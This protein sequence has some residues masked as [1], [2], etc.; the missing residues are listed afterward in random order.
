MTDDQTNSQFI[1]RICKNSGKTFLFDTCASHSIVS[2]RDFEPA[3]YRTKEFHWLDPA[4]KIQSQ[5]AITLELDFGQKHSISWEFDVIDNIAHNLCGLD[6]MQ[7][8]NITLHPQ[9]KSISFNNDLILPPLPRRR[10][11][12]KKTTVTTTAKRKPAILFTNNTML[13]TD[14]TTDDEEDISHPSLQ[15]EDQDN[16]FA[17]FYN[18]I[19]HRESFPTLPELNSS[20]DSDSDTEP[21]AQ[22]R[23]TPTERIMDLPDTP[24]PIKQLLLKYIE[25]T[26][27]EIS[28]MKTVPNVRFEIELIE[29]K[30]IYS[31]PRPVPVQ[32][33]K[34]LR[35]LLRRYVKYKIISRASASKYLQPLHVIPKKNGKIRL[36][37]DLRKLNEI[38]VPFKHHIPKINDIILQIEQSQ[39]KIFTQIDMA[40]G[41]FNI[42]NTPKTAE[43]LTFSTEFGNFKLERMA[44]GQ[45][46]AGE[47]FEGEMKI[48][49]GDLDFVQSYLD[50]LMVI[51]KTLPEHY[52]HLD[53]VFGILQKNNFTLSIEKCSF[54]RS[55]ITF[56][57]YEIS[58]T[59]VKPLREKCIAI[60]NLTLPTTHTGL[61]Q[62][63]GI[64][65]WNR[66]FIRMAAEHLSTLYRL[67]D[68]KKKKQAL[69]WSNKDIRAFEATKEALNNCIQTTYFNPKYELSVYADSSSLALGGALI[70]APPE[71]HTAKREPEVLD[72]YSRPLN[73]KERLYS[74]FHKELFAIRDCLRHFHFIIFGRPLKIYSDNRAVVSVLTVSNNIELKPIVHR[75]FN[76]IIQYKPQVFHITSKENFLSDCFSRNCIFKDNP[77]PKL[78]PNKVIN[79]LELATKQAEG[80]QLQTS[81]NVIGFIRLAQMD[82]DFQM[83]AEQQRNDQEVQHNFQ[84]QHNPAIELISR[85]VENSDYSIIG[86]ISTGSFR[87]YITSDLRNRFF[88]KY[89]DQNHQ[90]IRRSTAQI[91]QVVYWPKMARDL[92]DL[93]LACQVCARNKVVKHEK[94]KLMQWVAPQGKFATVQCDYT[95]R[96]QECDGYNYILVIRDRAT[97]FT[98]CVPVKTQGKEE[99]IF[100]FMNRWVAYFGVCEQL[101]SDNYSTFLSA[102]F[103]DCL[104]F[105]GITYVPIETYTPRQNALCERQMRLLK[106]MLRTSENKFNWLRNIA[107][108]TL[109]M[110]NL[111]GDN[112]V[113]ANQSTFGIQLYIP[114]ALFNENVP[115][116]DTEQAAKMMEFARRCQ[117]TAFRRH[118]QTA[119]QDLQLQHSTHV[120]LRHGPKPRALEERYSGPHAVLRLERSH[121]Y[122][123][124]NDRTIRVSRDRLKPAKLIPLPLMDVTDDLQRL[125]PITEQPFMTYEDSDEEDDNQPAQQ[126][127]PPQPDDTDTSSEHN[128]TQILPYHN[129]SEIDTD[130]SDSG[131]ER[132]ETEH[133]QNIGRRTRRTRTR[134]VRYGQNVFDT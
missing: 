28:M 63:I 51:S 87:P 77:L 16:I 60:R 5:G 89:H 76:E 50:D 67:I 83:L 31:R 58:A 3:V 64:F 23:K 55:S 81:N 129:E 22:K 8:Y 107:L 59:G 7:Y 12:T 26:D 20:D 79:E 34:K 71:T 95:G 1:S 110:N 78:K 130:S 90:G 92:K 101:T 74:I 120:Y 68:P 108:I 121:A 109:N 128:F 54:A 116:F 61:R 11:R 35:R 111:I 19:K 115:E 6:F 132:I 49:F 41:Y 99:L 82:D 122:I 66:R 119:I 97:R 17:P 94:L 4:M 40:D 131:T 69:K 32:L 21:N 102:E 85:R 75:A 38:S 73:D 42:L 123:S 88:H 52:K 72:L 46:S 134:P 45:T 53:I 86:D 125:R 106:Q 44:Q 91:S 15:Q 48:L 47:K 118:P 112:N 24:E 117:D 33:R 124:K 30:P 113:S 43:L 9:T 80:I 62:Y 127:T 105:L 84:N 56:L 98:V 103:Q 100:S 65:S 104:K 25:I 18:D 27:E 36:T 126:I 57:G 37:L 70:Q 29:D 13:E 39:G 93:V 10:Q 14:Q 114:G 2:S 96:L 133:S